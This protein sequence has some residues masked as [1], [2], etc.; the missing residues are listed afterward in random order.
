[1]T[2]GIKLDRIDPGCPQQNGGH[3]RM[4]RDMKTELQGQIDGSLNEHQKVFDKWRRDFNEVRPHEALGM[5]TPSEVYKK[6]E[7][8]NPG[9]YIELR[10]GRGYKIRMVNDRGFINLKQKRI[11]I[12]NPFSGYHVGVKEFTDKPMEIW[13][14]HFLLGIIN[15]DTGLIEPSCNI[16]HLTSNA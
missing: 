9:E 13:F 11:F 7:R 10:Y 1:M 4:H 8:K 14:G 16:F 5:K 2:L 12:G 15:P 6:S 3:E